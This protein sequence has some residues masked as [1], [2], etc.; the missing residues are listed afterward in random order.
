MTVKN[1]LTRSRLPFHCQY[2]VQMKHFLSTAADEQSSA[3]IVPFVIHSTYR[4][5]RTGE[6]LKPSGLQWNLPGCS[7]VTY[8]ALNDGSP[9]R[10]CDITSEPT[11][12][13][14]K[15]GIV[16]AHN[17]WSFARGETFAHVDDIKKVAVGDNG[18][19]VTVEWKDSLR[20]R[21]FAE[22]GFGS[23]IADLLKKDAEAI[24]KDPSTVQVWINGCIVGHL[25]GPSSLPPILEALEQVTSRHLAYQRSDC[26]RMI[27]IER[28]FGGYLRQKNDI[29][30]HIVDNLIA[31]EDIELLD[32]A[33][34]IGNAKLEDWIMGGA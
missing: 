29:F 5:K 8:V 26:G 15:S 21:I 1:R 10:L 24:E 19:H 28:Y 4:H 14:V 23:T 9:S 16:E 12:D 17:R 3:N 18:Q 34:L 25:R 13:E 6:L 7:H 11:G 27:R 33:T 20:K 2:S 32:E 30:E 22:D 31:M